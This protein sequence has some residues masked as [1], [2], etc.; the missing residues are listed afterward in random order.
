MRIV[1]DTDHDCVSGRTF[2]LVGKY[3]CFHVSRNPSSVAPTDSSARQ[4]RGA[5]IS[6]LSLAREIMFRF[7]LENNLFLLSGD[8]LGGPLLSSPPQKRASP[9]A[10]GPTP[11]P[12]SLF[13]LY[14][15]FATI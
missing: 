11:L 13:L 8:I 4:S 6:I 3:R 9:R 7:L 14:T 12:A 15:R 1:P 5:C 10:R 2:D